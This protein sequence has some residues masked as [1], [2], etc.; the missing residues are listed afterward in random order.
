MVVDVLG[1]WVAGAWWFSC[2]GCISLFL[3]L[4]TSCGV[5]IIWIHGE[6]F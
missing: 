5:G 1:G 3:G 6:M 4:M 2:F